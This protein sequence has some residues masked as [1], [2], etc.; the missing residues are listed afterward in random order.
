MYC[1]PVQSSVA[2]PASCPRSAQ[3]C[4]RWVTLLPVTE[5]DAQTD[6]IQ[7]YD[8]EINNPGVLSLQLHN[9]YIPIGRE[10]PD[11]IV[12]IAPNHTSAGQTT[13]SENVPMRAIWLTG[14]PFSLTRAVPSCMRQRGVSLC[15]MHSTV[16]PEEQ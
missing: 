7:V 4:R 15:P 16:W 12:G 8:T 14:S 2:A 11:F 3:P 6:E 5:A 1:D 13:S 9:N 10:R